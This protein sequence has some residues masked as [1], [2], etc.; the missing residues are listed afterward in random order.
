MGFTTDIVKDMVIK[1]NN[2]PHIVLEKEFYSPAKGGSF[3]RTK[4][5]NL[6]TGQ[7]IRHTFRTG[8]KLETLDIET[9][10]MQYLYADDN[11]AYFMDPKTFEQISMPVE[12]VPG[13]TDYLHG[14]AHYLVL[15]YNDEPISITIPSKMTLKVAETSA[16]VRGD[17][18]TNATKEAKLET[19]LTVQVP[20][21]V[22]QEDKIIVN[23]ETGMYVSK[24]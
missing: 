12:S 10:G 21:F 24:G 13:K 9:K 15:I 19:G 23:T 7:L 14:E 22:K 4:L 18:A 2:D 5:K 8:E 20:L 11:N 1:F 3:T 17:T 6:K 16:G